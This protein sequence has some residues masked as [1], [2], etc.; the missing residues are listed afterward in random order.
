MKKQKYKRP[1][2]LNRLNLQAA[3]AISSLDYFFV[4][5]PNIFIQEETTTV[6]A[7]NHLRC[8]KLQHLSCL[9]L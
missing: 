3:D 5:L 1:S 9:E 2:R 8:V 6:R 4:F 7:N